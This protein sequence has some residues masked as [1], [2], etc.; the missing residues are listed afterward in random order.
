MYFLFALTIFFLSE[1]TN[2]NLLSN[3]QYKQ[4]KQ[5]KNEIYSILW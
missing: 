5:L 1:L 2:L 3:K 4:N